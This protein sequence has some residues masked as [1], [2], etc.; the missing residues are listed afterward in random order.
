MTQTA[1]LSPP[2]PG[3]I[4]RALVSFWAFLEALESGGSG[5]T[6][7]RIDRL[8]REVARLKEELRQSRGQ[9]AADSPDAGAAALKQ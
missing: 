7:D 9:G 3:R 1:S 6:F 5:Y 2:Q 8:E 4:R